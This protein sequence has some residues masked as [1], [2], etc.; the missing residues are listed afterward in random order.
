MILQHIELVS[1]VK[2]LKKYFKELYGIG[3]QVDDM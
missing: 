2:T 1:F 3:I